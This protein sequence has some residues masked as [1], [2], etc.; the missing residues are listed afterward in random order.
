LQAQ[1]LSECVADSARVMWGAAERQ[2]PL[3]AYFRN[4]GAAL[5]A[6]LLIADFYLPVSPVAQRTTAYPPVIRIYAEP[7]LPAPVVFDPTQMMLAAATPAPW[8]MNPPAPPAARDAL[9]QLPRPDS[10]RSASLEQTK[11]P[12]AKKYAARSTRRHTQPRIVLASRQGQFSWF[13]FRYW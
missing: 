13:G 4:V 12:A 5:F 8:D 3:A 6:V 10:H 2:M 11:R 7:K 1:P 9:A